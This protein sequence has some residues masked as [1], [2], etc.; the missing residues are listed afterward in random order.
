MLSILPEILRILF[1]FQFIKTK[2]VKIGTLVRTRRYFVIINS[3]FTFQNQD[4]KLFERPKS[5]VK[6]SCYCH[7]SRDTLYLWTS[8]IFSVVNE[9]LLIWMFG[10]VKG[11]VPTELLERVRRRRIEVGRGYLYPL[12]CNC[13]TFGYILYKN[14]SVK[15]HTFWIMRFHFKIF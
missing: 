4:S 15:N 3:R 13:V 8:S 5:S 11:K 6:L 2:I 7:V 9:K 14:K 1:R 12:M 10:L